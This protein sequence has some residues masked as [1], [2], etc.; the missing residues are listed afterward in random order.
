MVIGDDLPGR[1]HAVQSLD[2]CAVIGTRRYLQIR[3]KSRK[4][5]ISD[6]NDE[7]LIWCVELPENLYG[8]IVGIVCDGY[9]D[10]ACI[11][12]DACKFTD[13]PKPFIR[14][15]FV[16]AEIGV[17]TMLQ[18]CK[19]EIVDMQFPAEKLLFELFGKT[20]FS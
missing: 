16:I 20:A 13:S 6:G 19:T 17:K 2:S 11:G 4:Q 5:V 15:V 7:H 3:G 9:E 10:E 1:K 14:V 8:V 18:S 12:K